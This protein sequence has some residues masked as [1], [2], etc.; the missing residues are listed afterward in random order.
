MKVAEFMKRYAGRLPADSEDSTPGKAARSPGRQRASHIERI[1][2]GTP[3]DWED[4][5]RYQQELDRLKNKGPEG[6]ST[7]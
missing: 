5:E 3:F 1:H 7:H 2:A 4:L 6:S